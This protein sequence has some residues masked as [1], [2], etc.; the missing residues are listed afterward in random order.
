MVGAEAIKLRK[1][2]GLFWSTLALVVAPVVVGY[3]VMTLQHAVD[4]ENFRSVGGITNFRSMYEFLTQVGVVAAIMVGVTAGGG[5]LGAGVFRELVLTGRSRI[6]LFAVRV[7]GGTLFLAPYALAAALIASVAAVSLPSSEAE[8]GM[9]AMVEY[10]GWL[11][12]ALVTGFALALGV[13]SLMIGRVAIALLL[14]WQFI[15]SPLLLASG[16]LDAFHVAA[17]L[18]RLEPGTTDRSISLTV[19]L[20]T[21]AAWTLIPLIVGGWRT[22]T[23][24]A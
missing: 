7:P 4:P 22:A 5:D 2:R 6:A 14:A 3:A 1:R 15:L 23:R 19:A 11:G 18:G 13:G 21:I 20:V 9:L 16:K 10:V 8:P 17:A 24:D 12:L